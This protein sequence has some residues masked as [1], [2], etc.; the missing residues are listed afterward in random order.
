MSD[1]LL[2]CVKL[3]NGDSQYLGP[4]IYPGLQTEYILI[5]SLFPIYYRNT[6]IRRHFSLFS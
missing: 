1:S 4:L 2:F 3:A 5:L 6:L